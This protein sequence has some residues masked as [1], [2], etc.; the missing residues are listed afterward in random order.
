MTRAEHPQRQFGRPEIL[1]I[2]FDLKSR[3]DIPAL[4]LGL[5]HLY[6]TRRDELFALLDERISPGPD[7]TNDRPEMDL[8]SIL[9]LG[10]LK[11][12]LG[13][14][15]DRLLELANEH[16]TLREIL[17]GGWAGR[18]RYER[19]I[20][21]GDVSLMTPD[22]LVAVNRMIVASGHEVARKKAWRLLA[23]AG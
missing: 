4:L 19:E 17:G 10:V 21:I 23:R 16:R 13:Y 18:E 14:D 2:R 15:W 7:Q 20:L 5:Q 9:V 8:W 3:A 11:Q 1:D 6:R 12:G 22:M